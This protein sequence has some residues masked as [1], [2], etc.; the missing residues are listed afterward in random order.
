MLFQIKFNAHNVCDNFIMILQKQ[1]FKLEQLKVH[2]GEEWMN[3]QKEIL[4]EDH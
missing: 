2:H 1:V 3:V 4:I